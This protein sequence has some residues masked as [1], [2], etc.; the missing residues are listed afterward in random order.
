MNTFTFVCE[1]GN[2]SIYPHHNETKS[3]ITFKAV[4][5]EDVV[6]HFELF[7]KGCGYI[8][9]GSLD[10]VEEDSVNE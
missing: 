3:T 1:E 10:F 2:S 8:L 9:P 4:T 5:L 7:L 6:N